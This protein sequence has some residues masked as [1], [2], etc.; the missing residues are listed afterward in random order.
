MAELVV[1]GYPDVGTACKALDTVQQLELDGTL[2]TGGAAVVR[3]TATGDVEMVARTAP[4]SGEATLGGYWGLLFGLLFLVPPG[5]SV[6]AP[7]EALTGVLG[8]WGIRDEFRSRVSAVLIPGT[9]ALALFVARTASDKVLPAL[10]PL[11]GEVMGTPLS[12]DAEVEI[13]H[14][15]DLATRAAD[16]P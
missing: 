14:A 12:E 3:R 5:A 15:V 6:G 2:L 1:I 7:K 13:Q 16:G 11:G 10:A 9:A 8:T 4:A